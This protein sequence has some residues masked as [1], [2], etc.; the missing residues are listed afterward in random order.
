M[1]NLYNSNRRQTYKKCDNGH[2]L[3]TFNRK[4]IKKQSMDPTI[5]CKKCEKGLDQQNIFFRCDQCSYNLCIEC[6]KIEKIEKC[7]KGHAL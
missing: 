5:I 6:G 4:S 3:S 7:V 2:S 1:G